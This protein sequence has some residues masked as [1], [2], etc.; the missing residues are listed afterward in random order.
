M[1]NAMC[2]GLKF[3]EEKYEPI[4]NNIRIKA[5]AA[6]N[7]EPSYG[8]IAFEFHILPVGPIKRIPEGYPDSGKFTWYERDAF[9]YLENAIM[10]KLN[11]MHKFE[12]I[13]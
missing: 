13:K 2:G 12:V 4:W 1:C 6:H 7:D 5:I 3:A 10:K 9:D 11:S 8:K